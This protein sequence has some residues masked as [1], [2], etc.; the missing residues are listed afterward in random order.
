MGDRT[1]LDRVID[2]EQNTKD[3]D[4][5]VKM[6]FRIVGEIER[7]EI[8]RGLKSGEKVAKRPPG[9]KPG[10]KNVPLRKPRRPVVSGKSK[11]GKMDG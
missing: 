6:L 9:P 11:E 4:A 3:M 5:A 8:E 2:L 10:R 7:G 1:I